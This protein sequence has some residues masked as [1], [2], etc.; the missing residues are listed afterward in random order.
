MR[1]YLFTSLEQHIFMSGILHIDEVM[2]FKVERVWHIR[3]YSYFILV[4]T[5][6]GPHELMQLNSVYIYGTISVPKRMQL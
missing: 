4:L 3:T 5:F 2:S 6:C 1:F